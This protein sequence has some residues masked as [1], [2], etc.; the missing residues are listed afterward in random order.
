MATI[1]ITPE[2]LKARAS[3]LMGSKGKHDDAMREIDSIVNALDSAWKGPSQDAF[4]EKYRSMKGRFSEF[5]ELLENYAKL[6]ETAANEMQQTDD[7]LKSRMQSF[8]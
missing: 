1:Q 6:M 5:A 4:V 2:E 7:T 8:G 3:S